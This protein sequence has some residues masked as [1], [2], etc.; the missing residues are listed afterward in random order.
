MSKGSKQR[1]LQVPKK[2]FDDNWDRIFGSNKK[3]KA[4]AL[5]AVQD[6]LDNRKDNHH[7]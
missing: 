1:P 4:D 7:D 5:Q 3:E 2:Q 6:F